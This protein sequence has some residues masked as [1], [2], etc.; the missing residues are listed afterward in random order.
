MSHI[1]SVQ[2]KV[3]D[4]AGIQAACRRLC[5]SKPIQGQARLFSGEVTGIV[6][7]LP[8]WQYPIVCDLES[9]QVQFDNFQGRWGDRRELDRF[10]QAYAVEKTKIEA[11][12]KGLSVMEQPLADGSIKLTVQVKGGAA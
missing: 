6:V 7:N 12:K 11:R 9:G 4:M 2:T 8:G 1:V 5:L 10:L 3:R